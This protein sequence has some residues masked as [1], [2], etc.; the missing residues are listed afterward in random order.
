M[1][2]RNATSAAGHSRYVGRGSERTC[3]TPLRSCS[4]VREVFHDSRSVAAPPTVDQRLEAHSVF[5]L[6]NA[7][8]CFLFCV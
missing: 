2:G 7:T 4:S 8:T 6:S 1:W 5:L 3:S